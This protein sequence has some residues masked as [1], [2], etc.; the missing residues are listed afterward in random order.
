VYTVKIETQN[1]NQVSITQV[2]LTED[3]E[4]NMELKQWEL[5][6]GL[7]TGLLFGYR[8]YPDVVDNKVDHVLYVFIFD[9]CLTLKY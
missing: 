4:D 6:F 5:S 2:L 8:S 9:I 1:K 3:K 7:F